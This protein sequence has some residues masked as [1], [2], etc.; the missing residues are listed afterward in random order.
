MTRSR[1]LETHLGGGWG[2]ALLELEVAEGGNGD[3]A[4]C[5]T[6]RHKVVTQA[7]GT[8]KGEVVALPVVL[9]VDMHRQFHLA[10]GALEHEACK[11]VEFELCHGEQAGGAG[12]ESHQREGERTA[13]PAES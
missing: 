6:L 7:L 8:G 1:L 9:P 12:V 13:K 4:A 5:D 11:V 3:A 2:V 10:T